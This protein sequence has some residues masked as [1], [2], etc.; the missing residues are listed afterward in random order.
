MSRSQAWEAME[1]PKYRENGCARGEAGLAE[2]TETPA[3]S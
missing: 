1:A 3:K 2:E